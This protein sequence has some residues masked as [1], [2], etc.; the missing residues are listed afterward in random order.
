MTYQ[1]QYSSVPDPVITIQGLAWR[2]AIWLVGL[3]AI[4]V[5]S[6]YIFTAAGVP[7]QNEAAVAQLEHS[8]SAYTELRAQEIAKN[9]F[10]TV[11][12]V[13]YLL[14]SL[15]VWAGPAIRWYMRQKGLRQPK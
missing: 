13:T 15:A 9:R 7:I 6:E 5:I 8:N 4:L 1:Q 10:S 12:V 3:W 11:V 14:W 2:C